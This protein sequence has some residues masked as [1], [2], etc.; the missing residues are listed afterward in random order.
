[1]IDMISFA[2]LQGREH[3][4]V[5][6]RTDAEVMGDPIP[7]EHVI[8]MEVSTVPARHEELPKDILLAFVCAGNVRSVKAAEYL[9]GLGYENII[10]LDKFSI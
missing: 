7:N 3:V 9:G 4:I 1:M 10:V 5:D 2:D 8:H 6:V